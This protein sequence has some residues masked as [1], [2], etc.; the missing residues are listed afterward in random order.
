MQ[1]KEERSRMTD[2]RHQKDLEE[3]KV[4]KWISEELTKIGGKQRWKSEE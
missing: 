4:E 3:G 2:G 1:G